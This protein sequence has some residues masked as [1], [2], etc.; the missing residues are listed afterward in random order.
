MA[1]SIHIRLDESSEAA[2]GL[3]RNEGLTDSEAVRAALRE[4]GAERS[5]RSALRAEA[6]RLAASEGDRAEMAAIRAQMDELAPPLD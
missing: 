2:L 1:R 4:A 5:T 3:M 6:A